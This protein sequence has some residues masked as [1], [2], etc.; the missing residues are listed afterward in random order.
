[1]VLKI[2][3]GYIYRNNFRIAIDLL[4][5]EHI[6]EICDFQLSLLSIFTP[7]NFTSFLFSNRTLFIVSS[8]I[9]LPL[10]KLNNIEQVFFRLIISL[11]ADNQSMTFSDSDSSVCFN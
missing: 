2:F 11:L 6:K 1:M 4:I 5:F 3:I 10:L 8:N 9:G 7:K